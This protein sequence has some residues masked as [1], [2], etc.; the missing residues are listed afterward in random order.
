MTSK[1][2]AIPFLLANTL[3]KPGI[4]PGSY[5]D[6]GATLTPGT[7][8]RAMAWATKPEVFISFANSLR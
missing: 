2:E 6:Y 5:Y 4:P 3:P 7:A 8:W 1:L